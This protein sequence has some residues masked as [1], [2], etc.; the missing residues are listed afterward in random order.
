MIVGAISEEL[1]ASIRGLPIMATGYVD[2]KSKMLNLF[3]A[4]DFTF[5]LSRV[6]NLPYMC[7]ESLACGRPVFGSAVGGIPEIV[8][9]PLLGW[10]TPKPFNLEAI[11]GILNGIDQESPIVREQRFAACRS[12]AEARFSLDLMVQRYLALYREL[13][14]A[15]RSGR[16]PDLA[17]LIPTAEPLS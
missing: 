4:A 10:L 14:S 11:V 5:A 7:V 12:S 15:S 9:D 6:D 8:N 2:D 1:S 3:A 16:R 13:L 17:K